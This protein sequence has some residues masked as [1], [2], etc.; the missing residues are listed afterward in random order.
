MRKPNLIQIGAKHVKRR[1][2]ASLEELVGS[3]V[4]NAI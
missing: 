3:K 4:A 2:D 1:I